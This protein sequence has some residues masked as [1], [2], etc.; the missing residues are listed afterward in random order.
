MAIALGSYARKARLLSGVSSSLRLQLSDNAEQSARNMRQIQTLENEIKELT[1]NRLP[2]LT[3]LN[4]DEVLNIGKQYVKNI[5][6]TRTGKKGARL[7]E[8]KIVLENHDAALQPAFKIILFDRSGVQVGM[9][10]LS[11]D[12]EQGVMTRLD[13]DEVRVHYSVVRLPDNS[14]PEYFQVI[15]L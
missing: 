3:G 1:L 5:V 7:Y 14:E 13:Q 15:L 11:H 9:S 12:S 4:Y 6:F 10:E 8:Y 2:G